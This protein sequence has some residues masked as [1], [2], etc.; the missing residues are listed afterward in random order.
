MQFP[1]LKRAQPFNPTLVLLHSC[2]Q[3]D[4][5]APKL[6]LIIPALVDN[7]PGFIIVHP[8]AAFSFTV[9]RIPNIPKFPI[10]MVPTIQPMT[11]TRRQVKFYPLDQ[12]NSYQ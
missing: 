7:H 8:E 11:I 3:L 6:V 4:A 1:I 10:L 5:L 9:I 2:I 12:K